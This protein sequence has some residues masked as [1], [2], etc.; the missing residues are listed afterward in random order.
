M[1]K[2]L[3]KRKSVK[4]PEQV[5]ARLVEMDLELGPLLRVR[6]V[7]LLSRSNATRYHAVATPGWNAYSEGLFTLRSQIIGRG[8]YG[9]HWERYFYKNVEG[10]INK[11]RNIIVG[12]CSVGRA[13]TVG[14]PQRRK[15]CGSVVE[16]LCVSENLELFGSEDLPVSSKRMVG[17]PLFYYLMVDEDG[18]VE[19]TCPIVKE[20]RFA[21]YVER[22]FLSD[23]TDFD[24]PNGRL[25]PLD[26]N[27]AID[28]FAPQI[29]RK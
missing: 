1:V 13:L 2:Q 4:E 17:D 11:N 14:V 20:K 15:E 7:A 12:F 3:I 16:S 27:D 29:V 19:L 9:E 10:I 26:D 5:P 23:G 21:D 24:H 6:D 22:I 8:R 25:M 18:R 28:D